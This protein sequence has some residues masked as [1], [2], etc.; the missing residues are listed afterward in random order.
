MQSLTE[1]TKKSYTNSV[2]WSP[3]LESEFKELKAC[4][5]KRPVLKLIDYNLPMIVQTDGSSKAIAGV[6]LQPHNGVN[7]PVHFVSRK[8]LPREQKYPIAEI[9]ALAVVFAL[10]KL[11]YYLINRRFTLYVDNSS[12]LHINNVKKQ[13]NQ[14]LVRWGIQLTRFDFDIKRISGKDNHLTDYLSRCVD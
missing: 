10:D 7:H 9:E 1:H 2:K 14:R 6:L 11:K 12:L 13:T 8:L 3:Q 5:A 4:L